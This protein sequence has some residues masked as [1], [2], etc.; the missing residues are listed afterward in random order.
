MQEHKALFSKAHEISK[1]DFTVSFQDSQ[2]L[3]RLRSR[4]LQSQ[5]FVDSNVALVQ[6]YMVDHDLTGAYRDVFKDYLFRMHGHA[7]IITKSLQQLDGLF[8]V[9]SDFQSLTA[10]GMS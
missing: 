6:G 5:L 10:S 7:R 8:R 4:M 2:N 3:Q 9:V 1:T